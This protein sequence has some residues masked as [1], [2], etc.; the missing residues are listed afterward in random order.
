MDDIRRCRNEWQYGVSGRIHKLREFDQRLDEQYGD[1]T[2]SR[3]RA[4]QQEDDANKV[5]RKLGALANQR[6]DALGDIRYHQGGFGK[7]GESVRQEDTRLDER[8]ATLD[9]REQ[10]LRSHNADLIRA[11]EA[12]NQNH[13][14]LADKQKEERRR[15]EGKKRT[16]REQERLADISTITRILRFNGNNKYPH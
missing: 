9:A 16:R 11:N 2:R 5:G 10:H 13:R 7:H 12:M 14:D 3:K 8:S 1:L 6:V 4:K 15:E